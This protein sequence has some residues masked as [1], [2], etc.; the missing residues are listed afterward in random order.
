M[1]YYILI[2]RLK[3]HEAVH[4][5]EWA[6]SMVWSQANNDLNIVSR[7][8]NAKHRVISVI[9]F[10]GSVLFLFSILMKYLQCNTDR[11]ETRK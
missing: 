11:L 10:S 5:V 4:S 8:K 9:L 1:M 3:L 2:I 6:G 7:G